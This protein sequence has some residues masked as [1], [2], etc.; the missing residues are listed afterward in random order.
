MPTGNNSFLKQAVIGLSDGIII[1]FATATA[2]SVLCHDS[3]SVTKLAGILSL[4]ISI[5]MGIGGYLSAKFRMETLAAKTLAEEEQQAKEETEKTIALF[6][7]LG[8]G[9]EMQA[10]AAT[11]IEKDSVEWKKFLQKNQQPF[12]IPD[13]KTLPATGLII[14]I[15]FLAGALVALLPYFIFPHPHRAFNIS[16]WINVP[17]LLAVGYAKSKINGE[18]IVWG[19]IR[20]ALLGAAAAAA[21]YLVAGL[22]IK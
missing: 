7:H 8:I 18:P 11:E 20:L 10:Q 1:A 6:Q 19:S 16:L 4:G 5:I 2:C 13:K 12:E 14:G 17:V 22:F 21:A 15:T 9:K 3:A